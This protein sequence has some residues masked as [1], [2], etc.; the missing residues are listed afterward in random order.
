[1]IHMM[2]LTQVPRAGQPASTCYLSP[3]MI[4]QIVRAVYRNNDLDGKPLPDEES[5]GTFIIY[6]GTYGGS[7]GSIVVEEPPDEVKKI[8]DE[9][10]RATEKEDAAREAKK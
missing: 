4:E 1:M 9:A 10:I 7:G 2:R 5:V 8:R 6:H 3:F